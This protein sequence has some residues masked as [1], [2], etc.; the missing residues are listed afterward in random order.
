MWLHF[1]ELVRHY[2]MKVVE[3]TTKCIHKFKS[4][5]FAGR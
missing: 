5:T 2:Q 1:E 4:H 3:G